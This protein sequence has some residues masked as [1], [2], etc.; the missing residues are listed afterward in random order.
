VSHRLRRP[1]VV[2]LAGLA[3]VAAGLLATRERGGETV[4][5]ST[6]DLPLEVEVT[7]VLQADRTHRLGPP[8]VPEM[9]E[10]KIARMAAEGREVAAGQEVLAFDTVELERQ[11]ELKKAER[12]EAAEQAHQR[13]AELAQALIEAR[14]KLAEAQAR[15]RK[16]RLKQQRPGE[17]VPGIE[18]ALA[19]LE[20]TQT[21]KEL[22]FLEADL[23][24]RQRAGELAVQALR[25]RQQVAH[26]RVRELEE[27]I[28]AMSVRAPAAGVVVHTRDWRDEKKKVGDTCWF[29]DTVLEIPDLATLR[30]LGEVE[31]AQAGRVA[32]G[33]QVRA[34]LDALPDVE[35][36]GAVAEVQRIIQ[37]RSW[38][39]PVKVMRLH[40]AFP[41]LD[42][43]RMR[44]GMRFTGTI[45]VQRIPEALTVPLEAVGFEQGRP[46]VQRPGWTGVRTVPVALGARSR[47]RVQILSGLAAG[48]KILRV[49]PGGEGVP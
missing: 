31:E 6:G 15:H 13:Q 7:G 49:F 38:R 16:A 28:A 19:E 2:S 46:V 9:W 14:L 23:V 43:R 40:I 20:L 36:T 37:R 29:S 1:A 30:G 12:D 24:A 22:L 45:E 48:E 27:A 21:E 32:P 33:Q 3:L 17:L 8:A 5:V 44:P 11:L 35:L 42:T 26:R 4:R 39:D 47:T 10:F 41:H 34:R 18:V 25:Q